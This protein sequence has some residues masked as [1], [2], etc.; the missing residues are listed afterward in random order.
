MSMEHSIA[1]FRECCVNNGVLDL[2]PEMVKRGW[3]TLGKFAFSSSYMP[4]QV[5]EGPF[6]RGVL[7]TLGLQEDDERIAGVRRVVYEEF[8]TSASEMRRRLRLLGVVWN[9]K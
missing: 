7:N 4:G 6:V 2:H 9:A 3:P 5:D 8:T 1:Y